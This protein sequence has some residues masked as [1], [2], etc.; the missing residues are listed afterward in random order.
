M[1]R[2]FV[3]VVNR[4]ASFVEVVNTVNRTRGENNEGRRVKG[5]PELSRGG[6]GLETNDS[7]QMRLSR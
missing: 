1:R 7:M 4:I 2:S 5:V 3:R 6:Y